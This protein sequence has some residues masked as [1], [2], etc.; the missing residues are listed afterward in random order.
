[1]VLN[2]RVLELHIH[3]HVEPDERDPR[4]IKILSIVQDLQTKGV[5][6]ATDLSELT[7]KVEEVKTVAGSAA[8]LLDGLKAALDAAGTDPAALAAL[9]TSLGD[10]SGVLVDAITRNTPAAV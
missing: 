7:A 4:I 6:M 10:A 2:R 9:S 8:V 5:T 3:V 1:V